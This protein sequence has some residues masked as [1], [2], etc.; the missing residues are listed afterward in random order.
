MNN[1]CTTK[2]SLLL[3][4]SQS[5]YLEAEELIKRIWNAIADLFRVD[6]GPVRVND[7]AWFC[8]WDDTFIEGFI[9][10]TVSNPMPIR[11]T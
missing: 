5:A 1:V 8:H 10:A 4:L 9:Y 11:P 6:G 2:A 3:T 7:Q